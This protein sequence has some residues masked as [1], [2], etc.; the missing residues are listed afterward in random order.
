MIVLCIGIAIR[1]GEAIISRVNSCQSAATSKT[2]KAPVDSCK[3]RYSKYSGLHLSPLNSEGP[4]TAFSLAKSWIHYVKQR[5]QVGRHL[6]I[7]QKHLHR[8]SNIASTHH[9]V[10]ERP[11]SVK[12]ETEKAI[13]IQQYSQRDIHSSSRPGLP[14]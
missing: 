1:E 2:V 7:L 12:V 5:L 8:Y 3:Q 14:L 13:N 4:F 9:S 11:A 10:Y 6:N